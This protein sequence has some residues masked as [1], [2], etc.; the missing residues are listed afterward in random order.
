MAIDLQINFN[1]SPYSNTDLIANIKN[2]FPKGIMLKLLKH[3]VTGFGYN[4]SHFHFDIRHDIFNKQFDQFNYS[5]F[6]EKQ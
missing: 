3:G 6:V 4:E 5:V 1:R 2:T